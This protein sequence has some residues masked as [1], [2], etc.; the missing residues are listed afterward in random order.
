ME[1]PAILLQLI[2]VE[3]GISG[4]SLLDTLAANAYSPEHAHVRYLNGQRLI[5]GWEQLPAAPESQSLP[6]KDG[7]VYLITGGTGGLGLL[8][9]EEIA[10]Q[11]RRPVIILGAR[12]APSRER[13]ERMSVIESTGA[14]VRYR[15]LDVNSK[16]AVESLIAGITEEHGCLDG[17]VHASGIH[18]DNFIVRKTSEEF[19]DVVAPKVNGL[20]NLDRASASLPLDF[21]IC[22]SSAAG[23]LGNAG[24]ADYAAGNAFMDAFMRDRSAR[25]ATGE[26]FGRSLSINWPFWKDGGMRID[27]AKAESLEREMGLVPMATAPG[28]R[29]FYRALASDEPQVLVL[30]GDPRRLNAYVARTRPE[31]TGELTSDKRD[32][33]DLGSSGD[34]LKDKALHYFKSLLSATLK[35]PLFHMRAEEPLESYGLDS[36]MVMQLTN[37]LEKSFGPLSKTLFFEYQTIREVT[38]YFLQSHCKR[39]EAILNRSDARP[40]SQSQRSTAAI[41][42]ERHQEQTTVKSRRERFALPA[43]PEPQRPLFQDIAIIGLSGRYPQARDVSAYW[44]NL[45]DGKDCITEVPKDRWD[46]KDYYG[47][48]GNGAG[49]HASKWGG[50]IEDVDKFDP[51]FFNISPREAEL[52]DPQERLFLEQSWTALEDAGYSRNS[53]QRESDD[54]LPSQVGVYAGVMYGEYQLFGAELSARGKRVGFASTLAS[55]AN[56]VSYVLNLHGP[57]MTVDT[58]CS[59]SLTSIHLAC[60]DLK[61]GRTDMAL[62]GG[63]NVTIHPNKYLILTSGQ[64]LSRSGRCESFG[65]GGDGYIPSE[66]VGV[67]VLKRLDEARRDGD[68]IYGVIRGSAINHG[69]RTNGYSVP[70]PNAQQMV[71]TRALKEARVDPRTVS[72]VEAHGTG[73]RLGDPIEIAGLTKAFGKSGAQ[74]QFCW[75]GSA[76]SNIGHCESAAGVAGLTKVLLQMQHGQIVPSLHSESLNPNIAFEETAFVV[77]QELRTWEPPVVDGVSRP[78]IAGI[79]SFGA[80]G[81]NAHLIVEEFQEAPEPAGD[82]RLFYQPGRRHCIVMSA[83]TEDRL[84]EMAARLY[85]FVLDN[86]SFEIADFA[87]TL[88]VGRE[89]MEFR[90]GFTAKTQDE[91]KRKLSAFLTHE[92]AD[93]EIYRGTVQRNREAL[94]VI[95]A[96]DDMTRA[97]EA[98]VEKGKYSRLLNLWVK[99]LSFDWNRIYGESKPRRMSLPTYPFA[100]ERYWVP[101]HGNGEVETAPGHARTELHYLR[102]CWEPHPL[103]PAQTS[104][105]TVLILATEE[106]VGWLMRFRANSTIAGLPGWT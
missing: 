100:R 42:Q 94:E 18:R 41:V 102:K 93:Q 39:L 60:Q 59:S 5:H 10:M 23:A 104:R 50:F 68:H 76:K 92:D 90:L 58:M 11:C 2:E 45:R 35:L 22:F 57:S 62:A 66:G 19:R 38:G 56:R 63:V 85:R 25:V 37:R 96:D 3:A 40:S 61:L 26:R 86:E 43:V 97:L 30:E 79:S 81:S 91:L 106:L 46:W 51:L 16:G 84:A 17:I 44:E 64:F 83:K 99:G 24:Q 49:R 69:G 65:E 32:V 89:E 103:L 36:I 48:N 71:V 105:R 28:M 27:P 29:A 73:T 6:W 34:D 88:Q 67:V 75:I 47:I 15:Q 77:N 33:Q 20:V 101:S 95:A 70:N 1:N 82:V 31:V 4:P 98:W 72:Y 9:A 7:G 53:L 21:F 52:I 13:Q 8:F 74:S 14:V 55:V 87:Y 12:S 54:D 78:R 80:G